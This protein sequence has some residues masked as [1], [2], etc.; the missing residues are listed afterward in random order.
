MADYYPGKV[1]KKYRK[2]KRWTQQ[3][4]AEHWPKKDGDIGVDFH[5]I[6][7]VE[8]GKRNI[9]AQPIL[10]KVSVLLDIPLS[11]FGYC[12]YDPYSGVE[13]PSASDIE[14]QK[15]EQSD[16][17]SVAEASI[18]AVTQED[19]SPLNAAP[20]H[21]ESTVESDQEIEGNNMDEDRR[22]WL[23]ETIDVARTGMLLPVGE[24][25]N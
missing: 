16:E 11:E 23:Q 8:R 24:E 3:K 21:I 6:Q 10:R 12:A 18:S 22:L 19:I 15:I 13:D 20:S 14:D 17:A 4:L 7:L 9:V 25:L 1:I 2:L 5:Y